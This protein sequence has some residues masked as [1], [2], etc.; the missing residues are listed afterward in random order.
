MAAETT[1]VAG[2]TIARH[3]WAALIRGRSGQGKSDLALRAISQPLQLPGEADTEPFRLVSDDQTQLEYHD[4]CVVSSAPD[5][6]RGRLEVRGIGIISTPFVAR[7]PLVVIVDISSTQIERLPEYPGATEM[8]LGNSMDI[9][10]V[11]AFE[12]SAPL[13]I[14]LAL[15][16]AAASRSPPNHA[17]T[18]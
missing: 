5:A 10:S 9:I 14:A 15:T 3:G 17:D 2:T 6:L 7:I 8:L 1:I 13:K 12:S 18:T 16:R 4:G 11:S